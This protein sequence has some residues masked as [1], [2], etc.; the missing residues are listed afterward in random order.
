MGNQQ[1]RLVSLDYLAGL[2][3]GE[4]SFC[5]NIVRNKGRGVINPVFQMFMCDKNTVDTVY[6]S[7]Q[8]Y[9]LPG[10]YYTRHKTAPN[11]RDQYGIRVHGVKRLKRYCDTFA[12][13]LTGDK[14]AAAQVV[15]EFCDYRLSLHLK[16]GYSP[17]DVQ[18]VRRLREINGN[19]TV[20]RTSIDELPRILRDYM[21]DIAR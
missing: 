7:L 20:N 15:G 10:Y 16:A 19:S 5:F 18:F 2:F 3:V 1:E 12:P 8:H 14:K 6:A 21:S 9:G 17:I 13:I 4:G 11:T